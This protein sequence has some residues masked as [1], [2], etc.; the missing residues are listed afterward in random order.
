[1]P[2]LKN[3]QGDPLMIQGLEHEHH[4]MRWPAAASLGVL[5]PEAK[6]PVP[7]L[8]QALSRSEVERELLAIARALGEIRPDACE[9]VPALRA[10][11]GY[12]RAVEDAVHEVV[13]KIEP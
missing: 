1:M 5:G 2:Q 3:Y 10:K 4:D 7:A 8:V 6:L 12:S 13:S 11:A 9:A